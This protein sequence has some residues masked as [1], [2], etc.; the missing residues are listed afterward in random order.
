MK[1]KPIKLLVVDDCENIRDLM[2]LTFKRQPN[3]Q[4]FEAVNAEEGFSKYQ[5]IDPDI[6]FTD[7]MMSGEYDGVELCRMIKEINPACPLILI[8]GNTYDIQ[9]GLAAGANLFKTKPFSPRDLITVV[10]QFFD[11]KEPVVEGK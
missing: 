1:H 5:E 3:I 6:V 11:S 9:K 4:L 10:Q 2:Y 8:S 7:I